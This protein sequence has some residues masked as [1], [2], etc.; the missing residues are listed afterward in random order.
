MPP[1]RHAS[2]Q[3]EFLEFLQGLGLVVQKL[4]GGT[5]SKEEDFPLSSF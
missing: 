5:N 1:I 3:S 4:R 2:R